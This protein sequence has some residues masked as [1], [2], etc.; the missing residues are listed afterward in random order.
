MA[1]NQFIPDAPDTSHTFVPDA[2]V[3]PRVD[4]LAAVMP[5]MTPMRDETPTTTMGEGQQVTVPAWSL[6]GQQQFS[7]TPS[8]APDP[9]TTGR[10]DFMRDTQ[11][12]RPEGPDPFGM[13][14][15]Q[16][17]LLGGTT[18]GTPS[19]L[20]VDY[21]LSPAIGLANRFVTGAE[22]TANI[23]G[24]A[25]TGHDMS[26]GNGTQ[27]LGEAIMDALPGSGLEAMHTPEGYFTPAVKADIAGKIK[28]GASTADILADH[29]TL[30]NPTTKESIEAN[31]QAVKKGYKGPIS[32]DED[33]PDELSGKRSEVKPPVNP[34]VDTTH[35][36]PISET[37]ETGTYH[38]VNVRNP[39]TGEVTSAGR[40]YVDPDTG[41]P[42]GSVLAHPLT[43]ENHVV[44]PETQAVIESKLPGGSEAISPATRA[45]APVEDIR[46]PGFV[47]TPNP[48]P[49]RPS[50]TFTYETPDGKVV[51]GSYD[52]EGNT[53]H[54]IDIGD[55]T[56]P[57]KLGAGETL[58]LGKQL[59]AAHPDVD[60]IE[61]LRISGANPDR[62]VKFNAQALRDRGQPSVP[63]E[64]TVG[65][66]EPQ[67]PPTVPIK[68]IQTKG[69]EPK[70]AGNDNTTD[71]LYKR[72]TPISEGRTFSPSN[73][74]GNYPGSGPEYGGF[75]DPVNSK[76]TYSA[77]FIE[78][79]TRLSNEIDALEDRIDDLD[80]DQGAN[81]QHE[82]LIQRLENTLNRKYG[83][84]NEHVQNGTPSNDDEKLTVGDRL[85][86]AVKDTWDHMTDERSAARRNTKAYKAWKA[87]LADKEAAETQ[88]RRDWF[89]QASDEEVLKNSQ[90]H[91]LNRSYY[92]SD[93]DEELAKEEL[94]RRRSQEPVNP[95]RDSG[96][97]VTPF[98]VNDKIDLPQ[99]ETSEQTSG[100]G[101]GGRAPDGPQ[102]QAA[103]EEVA[104]TG[105]AVGPANVIHEPYEETGL[106]GGGNGN[107][108]GGNGT[109]TEVGPEGEPQPA[110]P[111]MRVNDQFAGSINKDKVSNDPDLRN[112]YDEWARTTAAK[113][114]DGFDELNEKTKSYLN[115]HNNDGHGYSLFD[116]P[117]NAR[118]LAP[119]SEAVRIQTY[120]M[121]QKLSRVGFEGLTEDERNA[122]RAMFNLADDSA[123]GQGSAFRARQRQ[124]DQQGRLATGGKTGDFD[125]GISNKDVQEEINKLGVNNPDGVGKILAAS[126]SKDPGIIDLFR[127]GYISGLVSNLANHVKI[128]G[129]MIA[130][131]GLNFISDSLAATAG[132]PLRLVPGAER[133]YATQM[134][135]RGLGYAD[136][137]V[138]ALQKRAPGL[139][140][141]EGSGS[142]PLGMLKNDLMNSTF[143]KRPVYNTA[144]ALLSAPL[145]LLHQTGE[146]VKDIFG[147]SY[148]WDQAAK[149]A[150]DNGASLANPVDLW[151]KMSDA[152]NNPTHEMLAEVDKQTKIDTFRD[153]MGPMGRLVTGA[154]NGIEQGIRYPTKD[155]SGRMITQPVP[156]V[157]AFI[158]PFN[159][160]VD[161]V[162]R[163]GIRWGPL[164]PLDRYNQIG[165]A[166]GGLEGQKAAARMAVA[167]G[168]TGLLMQYVVQDGVINGSNPVNGAP[169]NSMKIG[170]NYYTIKGMSAVADNALLLANARDELKV[171]K[172][173]DGYT[174]KVKAAFSSMLKT[175]LD[176]S[177]IKDLT[178]FLAPLDKQGGEYK[179]RSYLTSI[180]S[181]L[182]PY[183]AALREETNK[184]VPYVTDTLDKS[185]AQ[186]AVN[187][188]KAILP[189]EAGS[190]PARLDVYGRP[191]PSRSGPFKIQPVEQDPAIQEV[192]RLSTLANKKMVLPAGKTYT[193]Y[194]DDV[195]QKV[196]FTPEQLRSYQEKSGDYFRRD[197][198]Q[199]IQSPEY[200][201]MADTDK[202]ARLKEVL[203]AQ[204]ENA[205]DE[206]LDAQTTAPAVSQGFVSDNQFIPD[207]KAHR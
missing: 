24:R 31:V 127:K 101:T 149:Y 159:G 6:K 80:A 52:V 126:A 13:S 171:T 123:Y 54:S 29:P 150:R 199:E 144:D 202:M 100:S 186:E 147:T 63:E 183:N 57:V 163:A 68:T 143:M 112:A 69:V 35:V 45:Q 160:I 27:S 4:P 190:L 86:K 195:A 188:V 75:E 176:E 1:S 129:G 105:A 36:D 158:A 133:V 76:N 203:K 131:N 40:A 38:P 124:I 205:R 119:W 39:D 108:N 84:L 130:Q 10:F 189:W 42:T 166:K 16:K 165:L 170:D 87:E 175:V 2:P 43:K 110:P 187:K 11:N 56:N 53:I 90:N 50:H 172:D 96:K 167:A 137:F 194:D 140:S 26:G 169:A 198:A 132:Q 200:Q 49:G 118:E 148:L 206:V 104:P 20:L 12:L 145:N 60:T 168:L 141:D 21:G 134:A 197:F 48:D 122:T 99:D 70:D 89:R 25:L 153:P 67:A 173:Q 22:D 28:A 164:A 83:E 201:S 47:S 72:Y 78:K 113:D 19:R 196:T 154:A 66:E 15:D 102:S 162:M 155:G 61:G 8:M 41:A 65:V 142:A 180:P 178:P 177:T 181:Q 157:S 152:R 30:D 93:L 77:A 120:A 136:G 135:A 151:Q 179:M 34:T 185:G 107:G 161:G 73:D 71:P 55:K 97:T 146:F 92:N 103:P 193:A 111:H 204:R 18:R 116:G 117:R 109:G 79:H 114:K 5:S 174:G 121:A 192:N 82:T 91:E 33:I 44:T 207:K 81:G 51:K 139:F 32:F 138:N 58:N 128:Y 98:A 62:T 182:V 7:Q 3:D 184:E 9:T 85:D 88:A 94:E 37:D 191:M 23:I 95:L 106:I 74:N 14:E 17:D 59:A 115:D 64:P 125:N 156:G 46:Q